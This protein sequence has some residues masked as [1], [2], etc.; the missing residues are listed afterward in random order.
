MSVL[1]RV[2]RNVADLA[3][4]SVF[5]EALGFTPLRPAAEDAELAALLAIERVV[6]RLFGLGTQQLELTQCTP[7]G[8]AYPG[9]AK[10]NDVR[11]QHIAMVTRDIFSMQNRA[12]QA[13]ATSISHGGP[14][15]LPKESGGVIAWKFRDP[16]GHPLE[17]L[18]MPD[19][20][21]LTTGYDHSAICVTDAERSINFYQAL[22]LNLRH[23]HVNQGAAQ[24]R[25]DGLELSTV[26]VIAMLP[27]LA[28]PHVELLCYPGTVAAS[29]SAND[30]AADRLV[31]TNPGSRLALKRDPDGHILLLDARN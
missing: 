10:S 28:P 20:A 12:L 16:E 15:R 5:Y 17:F 6:S 7:P 2:A 26:E 14:Q 22:G 31:F 18:E 4:A 11:F 23:R 19:K 27:A 24:A 8:L 30:I 29:Q 25:L 3:E 13:G 9:S 21:A 1:R